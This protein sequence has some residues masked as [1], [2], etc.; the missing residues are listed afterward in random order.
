MKDD[1]LRLFT[2]ETEIKSFCAVNGYDE[3]LTNATIARWK[4]L[5]AEPVAVFKATSKKLTRAMEPDAIE[6]KD[7]TDLTE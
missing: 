1:K 6:S 3:G 4:S 5:A 2:S 7:E